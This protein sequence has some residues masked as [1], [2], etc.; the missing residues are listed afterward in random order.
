M[1]L[2]KNLV[3][4]AIVLTVGGAGY[5]TYGRFAA[6]SAASGAGGFGGPMTVPVE[7][8]TAQQDVL[9]N[10]INAVGTLTVESGVIVRPEISGVVKDILFNDGQSVTKGQPLVQLDDSVYRAQLSEAQ[11]ALALAERTNSRADALSKRGAGTEQSRDE[12]AAELRR[13]AAAVALAK[14][15]LEK[16][17]IIAPFNGV[18]GIRQISIGDYLSPG[19]NIVSLQGLSTM[20]VDF[21]VPETVLGRVSVGQEIDL[22]MPAYEGEIFK[23][24]VAAIDPLVDAV[25]RSVSLR[26]EVPNEDGRL[27]PGLYAVVNLLLGEDP[28]AVFIPAS[29]IWPMGQNN[30]VFK[31]TDN[32]ALMVPVVIA[33]RDAERVAIASGL[34]AGDVVATSGQLK[35][36]MAPPNVPVPVAI[37]PVSSAGAPPASA[38]ASAEAPV[39]EPKAD[40][41]PSAPAE[42]K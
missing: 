42:N 16:T 10:T 17:L 18:V 20:R 14:A 31:I 19:Q 5:L 29:A 26:A 2:Q 15:N 1:S 40:A 11:A 6:M 3:I 34:K 37:V 21:S 24:K 32:A 36:S 27:R 33:A 38:A 12:A 25:S 4:A 22:T 28:N 35:L 23:G 39:A 7:A 8:A 30:F 41:P 13:A 9:R